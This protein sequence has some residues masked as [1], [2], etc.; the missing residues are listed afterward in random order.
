[1]KRKWASI[2]NVWLD[3]GTRKSC[4]WIYQCLSLKW[5]RYV[6]LKNSEIRKKNVIPEDD[7]LQ[8]I[9]RAGI[10]QGPQVLF[11]FSDLQ[12]VDARIWYLFPNSFFC[13]SE[14]F[15]KTKF[16]LIYTNNRQIKSLTEGIVRKSGINERHWSDNSTIGT[17]CEILGREDIRENINLQLNSP[18]KY[19]NTENILSEYGSNGFKVFNKYKTYLY[20]LGEIVYHM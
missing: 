15:D 14:F 4:P 20:G 13:K 16:G 1:M 17:F 3:S 7:L 5:F 11:L 10:I 12:I 8:I 9:W 19:A 2:K 18:Q 6:H